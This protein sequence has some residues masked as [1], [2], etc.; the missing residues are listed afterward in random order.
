[1]NTMIPQSALLGEAVAFEANIP[2]LWQPLQMPLGDVQLMSLNRENIGA[3]QTMQFIDEYFPGQ[4]DDSDQLNGDLARIEFKLNLLM[5][6]FGKWLQA[7]S[8]QPEQRWVK[9][10]SRG[11]EWIEV[12]PLIAP[13]PIG[14]FGILTLHLEP[15]YPGAIRLYAQVVDESPLPDEA[16]RLAVRFEGLA[17]NVQNWLDKI[18]FRFHR[19]TIAYRKQ[20]TQ[21]DCA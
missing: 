2:L 16:F 9:M 21:R 3:L 13:I 6:L 11:L 7:N 5:E 10:H 17:P 12:V 20:Q 19:R 4:V 15:K 1:M 8:V 14:S 18:V